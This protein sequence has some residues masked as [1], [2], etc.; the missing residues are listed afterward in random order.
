MIWEFR[1]LGMKSY[2]THRHHSHRPV[3]AFKGSTVRSRLPPREYKNG[4]Y[5]VGA[6]FVLELSGLGN[7]GITPMLGFCTATASGAIGIG[8]VALAVKVSQVHGANDDCH[9]GAGQVTGF[10]EAYEVQ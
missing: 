1:I 2:T 9:A 5:Y 7:V 4:S 8:A 10:M 6:I 3:M